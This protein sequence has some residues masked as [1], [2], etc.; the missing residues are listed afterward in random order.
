MHDAHLQEPDFEAFI[1]G[2]GERLRTVA[3]V[4][5]SLMTEWYASAHSTIGFAATK[6]ARARSISAT[7]THHRRN[8]CTLVQTAVPINLVWLRARRCSRS[9]DS[10]ISA[11]RNVPMNIEDVR[12]KTDAS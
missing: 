10:Y 11:Q 12:N 6:L 4:S 8:R 9:T 1:R 7:A 2:D 5:K 3:I